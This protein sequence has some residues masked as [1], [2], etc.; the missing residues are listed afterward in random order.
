MVV[1]AVIDLKE[2]VIVDAE[3]SVVTDLAKRFVAKLMIGCS[4]KDGPDALLERFDETYFGQ[5]KSAVKTAIRMIFSK[6]ADLINT[7]TNSA[8]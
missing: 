2:N 1:A 7:Q 3:C 5:T 6:Y 4:M 8:K